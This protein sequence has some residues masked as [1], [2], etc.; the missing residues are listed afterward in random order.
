MD[1]QKY[2][3][4]GTPIERL[5]RPFCKKCADLWVNNYEY[6]YYCHE[7]KDNLFFGMIRAPG[8]YKPSK[9]NGNYISKKIKHF[10]YK[11]LSNDER[12]KIAEE[13]A[14]IL[15][16]YVSDEPEIIDNINCL[17]PI[18]ITESKENDRGFNQAEMIAEKFSEK[19]G[20]KVEEK[21]LEKIR[22]TE[23]QTT[24]NRESRYENVRDAF[25]VKNPEIFKEKRVLLIDDI[26]TTCATINECAKMLK[27]SGAQKVNAL[28]LARDTKPKGDKNE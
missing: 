26:A 14:N 11:P 23:S 25:H 12:Q 2:T 4:F 24:L 9:R 6:C 13:F 16:Q 3:L 8:I 18:P 27:N 15:Y 1:D 28:V 5:E 22:E 20:I 7:N 17:V 19:I 21:N 10:K